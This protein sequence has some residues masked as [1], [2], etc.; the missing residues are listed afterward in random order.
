MN[1][2]TAILQHQ[3]WCRD[4]AVR[5]CANDLLFFYSDNDTTKLMIWCGRA[6]KPDMVEDADCWEPATWDDVPLLI[7]L[8]D[9]YAE[10]GLFVW[11]VRKRRSP[12][13]VLDNSVTKI[14]TT[15]STFIQDYKF[16]HAWHKI[17]KKSKYESD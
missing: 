14:Y 5:L 3:L 2:A 9:R 15:V 11:C 7:E 12:R 17:T 13:D 6:F 16:N 1:R 10:L 8:F 4:A